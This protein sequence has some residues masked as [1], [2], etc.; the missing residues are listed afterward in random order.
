MA[1]DAALKI[2]SFTASTDAFS[3]N[4]AWADDL[5]SS[6]LYNLT[7]K[8][9]GGLLGEQT[10]NFSADNWNLGPNRLAQTANTKATGNT[11]NFTDPSTQLTTA[12]F[13]LSAHATPV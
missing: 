9:A 4:F 1:G 6:Q 13:N 5:F 7:A 8:E 10:N 12:G 3:G 2:T 11:V